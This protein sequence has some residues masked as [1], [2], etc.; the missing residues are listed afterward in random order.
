M[1][2]QDFSSS[3]PPG[4]YYPIAGSS[5]NQTTAAAT[6]TALSITLGPVASRVNVISQA[7]WS[8]DGTPAGSLSI[9]DAGVTVFAVDITAGGPGFI[10]FKPPLCNSAASAAMVA[11][12]ASGGA[13]KGKLTLRAFSREL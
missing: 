10:E 4:P 1:S 8:Y 13:V 3:V 2:L 9:T 5:A 11:T 12:L 7:I 6:G